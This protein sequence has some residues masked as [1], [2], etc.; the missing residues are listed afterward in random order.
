MK[1]L[2]SLLTLILLSSTS[3]A[4]LPVAKETIKSF[5][6]NPWTMLLKKHVDSD[7]KVNYKNFKVD[8]AKLDRYLNKLSATVIDEKVWNKEEQMAFWINAYNAFTVKL[9]LKHYPVKSIMELEKGKPWNLQFITIG[10]VKM[11]LNHIENNILRTKFNDPRIHFAIVCASYSCPL[12]LNTAYTGELLQ[13]QLE[14]QTKKFINDSKRNIITVKKAKLSEIFNWFKGDF[15]KNGSLVDF[16]NRYAIV[17]ITAK[18]KI[19]FLPYKWNL[20]E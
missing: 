15:T 6:H 10:G 16:I 11:S 5:D 19:S 1:L 14:E 4:N 8:E 18:T 3:F 13:G 7:G 12:L 20:N 2:F 9:I 17:K